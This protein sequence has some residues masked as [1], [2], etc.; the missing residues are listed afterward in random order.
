[1]ALYNHVFRCCNWFIRK[2]RKYPDAFQFYQR[3]WNRL[4]RK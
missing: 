3:R 1:M 2:L 4:G